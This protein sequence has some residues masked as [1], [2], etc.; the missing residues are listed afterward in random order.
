MA[1]QY[2]NSELMESINPIKFRQIKPYPWVNPMDFIRPERYE[3]LINEMPAIEE[4]EKDFA[5]ERK[6]DQA[7]HN[8]FVLKYRESINLSHHWHE[9]VKELRGTSYREFICKILNVSD[10]GFSFQWHYT[11]KGSSVSP[12]CDSRRKLGSHIFYMNTTNDWNPEWGGQTLILDDRGKFHR[13][14]SPEIDDFDSFDSATIGENSSLIFGRG[15][16]SW[17]AVRELTCPEGNYRK[18]FL[19][20]FEK[21]QPIKYLRKRIIRRI[22]GHKKETPEEESVFNI[23]HDGTLTN[24]AAVISGSGS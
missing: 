16:K 24:L 6:N 13:D 1:L 17:H 2:L 15:K 8:R 22:S 11:P 18:V 3:T 14:S 9:F 12:H 10:I 21:R 19:V 7:P 20:R 23:A 4:F 5:Y